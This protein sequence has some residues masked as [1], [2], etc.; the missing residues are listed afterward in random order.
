[1]PP[2]GPAR[3]LP[4]AGAAAP[5]TA[6]CAATRAR[7][8]PFAADRPRGA[9][10]RAAP[11]RDSTSC[12][13][14]SAD[15]AV[16]RMGG[17]RWCDAE[18]LRR[19]RRVTLAGLRREVEA[20][21]GEALARFLPRWQRV[22]EGGRGGAE[23]LRDAIATLQGLPL[24]VAI[25]EPRGAAAPRAG[26]PAGPA[27]RALRVRRGRVVGRRRRPRGARV[28]R[29]RAAARPAGRPPPTRRAASWPT[30]CA[31]GWPR[32]RAS[33]PTS[34]RR[35]RGAGRRGA[36]GAVGPGVGRRGHERHLRAAARAA[37]AARGARG[38]PVGAA[39]DPPRRRTPRRRPA[40]GAG[41]RPPRSSRAPRRPTARAPGPRCC[42]SA[43]AS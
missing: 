35:P 7:T 31:R 18:V 19:I 20:V 8:A 4:R 2:P 28:P 22:D 26:L 30:P 38:A 39:A 42:W 5:C 11:A 23:R 9:L 24:P 12:W 6:S 43:T 27:R 17:D 10:G 33:S 13:S 37:R 14:W 15:D 21:P 32:R 3:G 16:L 34:P 36:R 1:M 41:A 25:L 40:P 29:R